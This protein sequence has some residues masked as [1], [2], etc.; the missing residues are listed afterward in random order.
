MLETENTVVLPG[1]SG[2]VELSVSP[3]Y[4]G[5]VR[6][7]FK[8]E[9]TKIKMDDLF[10]FV[11]VAVDSEKQTDLIP[12]RHTTVTKYVKQ[13]TIQVKK[14]M[15]NGEQIVVNCE[16]DVPTT[17]VDALK[18]TPFKQSKILRA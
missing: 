10:G 6:L 11:F 14:D 9:S 8:G 1:L 4:P 16:I 18:G 7:T 5:E 3:A 15:K 13:H 2:D 17:V 12:V